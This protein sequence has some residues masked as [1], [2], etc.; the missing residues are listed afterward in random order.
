L[1]ATDHRAV[2]LLARMAIA[3]RQMGY[4]KVRQLVM[5][6]FQRDI[7]SD[8]D[9]RLSWVNTVIKTAPMVGL[10]GTVVGMMGAFGKLAG[11]QNVNPDVLAGDISTALIT[12]ALGLA[13]AIPLVLCTA[14]IR[15]RIRRM[16]DLVVSGMTHF[17]DALRTG[18]ERGEQR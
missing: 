3:N 1:L 4:A 13:I 17:F 5:D 12:T 9:Q 11:K 16:E 8:L 7:L 14:S 15:I 18:L 2:A 6:R 10:L